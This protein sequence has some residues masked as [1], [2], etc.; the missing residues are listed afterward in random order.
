MDIKSAII[1]MTHTTVVKLETG[2]IQPLIDRLLKI[3]YSFGKDFK[4]LQREN[5]KLLI[6]VK[7]NET[8][9]K[10]WTM[11]YGEN[12]EVISPVSLRQS[13]MET[14]KNIFEKHS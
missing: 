10:F 1:C 11:Q 2:A 7:V 12:V 9:M 8:A 6:N 13:I 5:E 3:T 4:I 14:A